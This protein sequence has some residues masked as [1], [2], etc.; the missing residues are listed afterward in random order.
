MSAKDS[1]LEELQHLVHTEKTKAARLQTLIK[2]RSNSSISTQDPDL[3]LRVESGP[4]GDRNRG[5][6][7]KTDV[8]QGASPVHRKFTVEAA[9]HPRSSGNGGGSNTG[10]SGRSNNGFNSG[11]NGS[12][13]NANNGGGNSS[14]GLVS[15]RDRGAK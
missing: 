9:I 13:S 10:A 7:N 11:S 14:R 15:A 6:V 2:K 1:E 8:A 12:S 3:T 4:S 5:K